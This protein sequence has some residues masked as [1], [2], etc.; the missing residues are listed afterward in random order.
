MSILHICCNYADSA[1]FEHVFTQ[2][3]A[4][5]VTQQVYVPEKRRQDMGKRP[6]T[7]DRLSVHYSLIVRPWD[8]FLYYTKGRRAVRDL[9]QHVDLSRATL[10]HAH[11]LF[12]DGAIAYRLFQQQGL[13]YVVTVRY[14]DLEV[15]FPVM[16]HLRGYALEILMHAQAIQFLSPAYRDRLLERYVPEHLR[17]TLRPKCRVIP[18]G[19]DA[20]WFSGK[21]KTYRAG[22]PVRIAFAGTL[23]GRKQPLRA[24]EAMEALE[25]LLPGVPVQLHMA[26]EGPLRRAL[27]RH[28]KTRSGQV[29]LHGKLQGAEEMKAFYDASTLFL[30]PSLRET[31]G[32][33][34]LEAMSR[35]LPVFYTHGQGFDGAFPAAQIGGAVDPEDPRQM[36]DRMTGALTRY[37]AISAYNTEAVRAYTWPHIAGQYLT[38]YEDLRPG[39]RRE[40]ER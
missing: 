19:I 35:G 4:L 27:E 8:R 40:G 16:P 9:P 25:V 28:P 24:L 20:T 33:V 29:V 13:P 22:Q 14:T 36:A 32:L 2:L 23:T 21:P 17:E 7:M 6:S 37:D 11:T 12:T 39:L 3:A 26:G 18:N 38:L 31:F 15:F 5:G 10:C 30:L 1:V 34:Y